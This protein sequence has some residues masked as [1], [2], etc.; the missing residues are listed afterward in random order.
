[1]RWEALRKT[2]AFLLLVF[3]IN[4]GTE[5]RSDFASGNLERMYLAISVTES[6]LVACRDRVGGHDEY[7][8]FDRRILCNVRVRTLFNEGKFVVSIWLA[9]I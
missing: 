2:L 4:S 1:M 9:Y 7:L 8:Q 6:Q 5:A 3:F